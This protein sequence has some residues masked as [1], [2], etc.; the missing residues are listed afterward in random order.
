MSSAIVLANYD[1]SL[2][3]LYVAVLSFSYK[4]APIISFALAGLNF[5]FYL[6][7]IWYNCSAYLSAAY[8]LLI[9]Y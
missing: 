2:L 7:F 5:S 8:F 1:T 3:A 4:I 6:G 9:V